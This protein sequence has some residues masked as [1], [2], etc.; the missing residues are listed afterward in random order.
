MWHFVDSF[1]YTITTHLVLD[2]CQGLLKTRYG[3]SQL[4]VSYERYWHEEEVR[5]TV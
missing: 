5:L 1:Q 2:G 3:E 4:K